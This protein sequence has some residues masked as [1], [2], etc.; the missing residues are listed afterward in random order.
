MKK[1][2]LVTSLLLLSFLTKAQINFAATLFYNSTSS[3]NP[4]IT[5]SYYIQNP[6]GANPNIDIAAI[7]FSIQYSSKVSVKSTTFLPGGNGTY[8][9]AA[10]YIAGYQDATTTSTRTAFSNTK[11]YT[12]LNYVRSTNLCSNLIS[13]PNNSFIPIYQ[14]VFEITAANAASYDFVTSTNS[15]YIGEFNSGISDPTNT[16][17]EILIVP[18]AQ[19]DQAG[20]S[21]SCKDDKFSLTGISDLPTPNQFYNTNAPLSVKWLSFDVVKQN[22]NKASIIWQTASETNN[23]GFEIQ[24]KTNGQFE[25]IGYV[26][27]SAING[28][29]S[30][31]LAYGFTDNNLPENVTAYY[32]I[33]QIGLEKSETYS[34]IKAIK[35]NSKS[36]QILVYPNPNNGNVNVILPGN[37]KDVSIILLDYSGKQIRKWDNLISPALKLSNL[38][39]GVYLLQVYN[40]QTGEKSVEKI[41]VL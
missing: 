26:S 38:T 13:V 29:S 22:G 12:V 33:K 9:D 3:P 23:K 35:N 6:S 21:Q 25:N 2:L 16:S 15:N 1:Y 41:T 31:T 28:N 20:N 39:K 36:L 5:V 8:L 37:I 11:S 17:K 30:R 7:S 27:S 24:R 10:D 14:I 34:E 18:S 32:R 40:S 19:F 4:T